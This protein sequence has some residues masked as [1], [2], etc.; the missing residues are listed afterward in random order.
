MCRIGGLSRS[1][2]LLLDTPETAF[3]CYI[4]GEYILTVNIGDVKS[5]FIVH[6]TP[7]SYIQICYNVSNDEYFWSFES[8][9]DIM[10]VWLR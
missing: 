2:S 6:I 5:Y 4:P 8:V 7:C 9:R 10:E 3:T 1:W